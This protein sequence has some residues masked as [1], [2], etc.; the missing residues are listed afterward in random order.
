MLEE[1]T[2]QKPAISKSLIGRLK[3]LS[4]KHIFSAILAVLA[5]A[6]VFA[7]LPYGVFLLICSVLPLVT[8]KLGTLV[9]LIS[10]VGIYATSIEFHRSIGITNDD[11]INCAVKEWE[12]IEECK[13]KAKD[14]WVEGVDQDE[15]TH[16]FYVFIPPLTYPAAGITLA[17]EYLATLEAELLPDGSVRVINVESKAAD[18][19]PI[20][21]EVAREFVSDILWVGAESENISF[22]ATFTMTMPFKLEGGG[23][24]DD[25]DKIPYLLVHLIFNFLVFFAACLVLGRYRDLISCCAS[26]A[27]PTGIYISS[28]YAC[29]AIASYSTTNYEVLGV[30]LLIGSLFL[31]LGAIASAM[32]TKVSL[33]HHSSTNPI[34][35]FLLAL[36]P[37]LSMSSVAAPLLNFWLFEPH[38][39]IEFFW[40]VFTSV[41]NQYVIV[42]LL[43]AGFIDFIF[44]RR[45]SARK[46]LDLL[47]VSS[48]ALVTI[49]LVMWFLEMSAITADYVA[50]FPVLEIAAIG[51][52]CTSLLFI[53][54]VV[55]A[56]KPI[57]KLALRRRVLLLL[58]VFTFYLFFAYAPAS[59]S[60]LGQQFVQASAEQ[61]EKNELEER[62]KTIEELLDIEPIESD[63][64]DGEQ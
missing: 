6:C 17:S 27:A 30:G 23:G 21:D 29:F 9:I 45:F 54:T 12:T 26:I 34:G 37:V 60:Q 33:T 52:A 13:R 53:V 10:A 62:L 24:D 49:S 15:N 22:P 18:L 19:R 56:N 50:I 51:V 47:I 48:T 35:Y 32:T 59:V 41:F 3:G 40:V 16:R 57:P 8:P 55:E 31:G 20:F 38:D 2:P 64:I 43:I 58:E 4:S 42:I 28:F 36:L 39:F 25:E 11:R 46:K 7:D 1:P 5:I 44:G 63:E 61:E 14:M